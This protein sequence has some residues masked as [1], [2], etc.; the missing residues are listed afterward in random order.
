MLAK[1]PMKNSRRMRFNQSLISFCLLVSASVI[2]PASGLLSRAAGPLD[3]ENQNQYRVLAPLQS[4]D[5]TIFPVVQPTGD[6][7]AER[8]Q[9]ITLDEGLRSGQVVVAEGGQIMGLIRSRHPNSPVLLRGDEVNRLVL[10]NNS[11]RPLLLL[12]GEIVAG[13]K[14][15]R[16]IGKDRI[17]PPESDPIDLSVFCIE[18]GRWTGESPEFHAAG[19]A[20]ESFMVQPEVRSKAMA[21][22]NQQ[23]VWDAVGSVIH[24]MAA[25]PEVRAGATATPPS[26]S[27]A[28][29]ME[30]A[31][32][33]HEVD[34]AAAPLL[35]SREALRA[36][37][38]KEHAVGVVV[39]VRGEIIW[40]DIFSNTEMLE[41]YWTKLIRSYAAE[42]LSG[43]EA[44]SSSP[45]AND[46]Q[47]FL[48]TATAG[49]IDSEGET[50]IYRYSTIRS[51]DVE[52]FV[53]HALLPDTGFDV[54]I[55]K[56]RTEPNAGRISPM[57]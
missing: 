37:L 5:L 12:A 10:I 8:W 50:D 3:T 21:M 39:A 2:L 57:R 46:A 20:G 48:A 45:T 41:Q 13:G 43:P 19:K 6:T 55:S 56:I 23:Q 30:S 22:Q 32:I 28:R 9:Y 47:R 34:K 38:G 33:E 16:V 51:S 31:A 25:A 29:N 7:K 36:E 27:Y 54:H 24:E 18:P 35:R 44:R 14:Q 42:A 40:A 52:S 49:H 11:S 26:T 17:V 53:L 1:A 15:D 4:G